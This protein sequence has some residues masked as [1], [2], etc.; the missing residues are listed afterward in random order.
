MTLPHVRMPAIM[1]SASWML[2]QSV[3]VS[4]Q[5]GTVYGSN[6]GTGAANWCA[7]VLCA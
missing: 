3:A 2:Q 5:T 1:R 4:S 6:P 7:A